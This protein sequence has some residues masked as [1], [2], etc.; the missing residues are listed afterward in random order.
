MQGAPNAE[1]RNESLVPEDLE[2]EVAP[3]MID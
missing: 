3:Q 1:K 2:F